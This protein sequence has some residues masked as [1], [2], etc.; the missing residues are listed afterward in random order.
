[1]CPHSG[2]QTKQSLM[3]SS[4]CYFYD[5]CFKLL[6]G[7]QELLGGFDSSRRP[8]DGELAS[9]T[10]WP[11]VEKIFGHGYEVQFLD[12]FFDSK[13]CYSQ[14]FKSI[15]LGVST[16]RRLIATACKATNAEH[17]V[18]RVYDTEG[19]HIVGEPLHGH[20]LSVTRVS[21]SPDD[22]YILTV[23]R[24][25]SWRLFEIQEVGGR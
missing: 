20:T 12:A 4:G 7:P 15:T 6:S 2:C 10:L 23:S 16:S 14:P 17:A 22:K 3:V 5:Q 13:Q 11:E 1:M 25:R 9:V 21:F 19:Y 8:F 18:V 24:D